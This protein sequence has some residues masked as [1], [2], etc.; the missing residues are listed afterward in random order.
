MIA[1]VETSEYSVSSTMEIE[2]FVPASCISGSV[3]SAG[4]VSKGVVLARFGL[5]D[6]SNSELF[7]D[8]LFE[9]AKPKIKHSG[10]K[11]VRRIVRLFQTCPKLTVNQL[12]MFAVARFTT[13]WVEPLVECPTAH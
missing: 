12:N 9:Q 5:L 1:S 7:R 4:A 13:G 11:R 2:V 10:I 3:P 6:G 8:S